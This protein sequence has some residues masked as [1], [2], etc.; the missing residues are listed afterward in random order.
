MAYANSYTL[1]NTAVITMNYTNV[2]TIV[3]TN[4]FTRVDTCVMA[5]V[6]AFVLLLFRFDF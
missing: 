4:M 3:N 6:W 2:N 1:C 5:M